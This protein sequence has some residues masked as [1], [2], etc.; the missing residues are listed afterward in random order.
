MAEIGDVKF[1][2]LTLSLDFL[3]RQRGL[4]TSR[5]IFRGLTIAVE[6]IFHTIRL[7]FVNKLGNSVDITGYSIIGEQNV[8]K[9]EGVI[10]LNDSPVQG[11][12]ELRPQTFNQLT[13]FTVRIPSYQDI[14]VSITQQAGDENIMFLIPNKTISAY[15][16]PSTGHVLVNPDPTNPENS[17]II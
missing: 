3:E 11:I 15:T 17:V 1:T 2:G 16:Q 8:Y 10:I 14:N 7:R 4:S 5:N 6:P 9:N 13:A 12:L